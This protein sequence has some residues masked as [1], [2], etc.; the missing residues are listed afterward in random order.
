MILF[1]SRNTSYLFYVLLTV[2]PGTVLVNYQLNAQFFVYVHCYSLHVSGTHVPII[3]R[4]IV[5]IVDDRLVCIP[6]G[7]L[8]RVT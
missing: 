2:H 7:H 4:I 3:R 1:T 8:H 6:D 5:S